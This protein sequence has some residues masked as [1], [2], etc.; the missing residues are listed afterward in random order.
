MY[1]SELSQMSLAKRIILIRDALLL[2]FNSTIIQTDKIEPF[3]LDVLC[4]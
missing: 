1:S 3:T 4:R 2:L